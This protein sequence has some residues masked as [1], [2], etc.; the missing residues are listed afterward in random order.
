ME[1]KDYEIGYKKPPKHTQFKPGQSGNPKGRPPK[2]QTIEEAAI[3]ILKQKIKIK[4]KD[5]KYQKTV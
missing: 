5:G 1:K 4:N 3:Q 2:P